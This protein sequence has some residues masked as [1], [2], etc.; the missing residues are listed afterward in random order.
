LGDVPSLVPVVIFL[1]TKFWASWRLFPFWEVDGRDVARHGLEGGLSPPNKNSTPQ[2]KFSPYELWANMLY[3]L[4]T[5]RC[6]ETNR[7]WRPKSQ[8]QGEI[9]ESPCHMYQF[10]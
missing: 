2:M 1:T 5:N 4:E 6:V 10:T 3:E 8:G 9:R 7:I